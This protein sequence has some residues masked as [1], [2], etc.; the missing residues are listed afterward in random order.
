MIFFGGGGGFAMGGAITDTEVAYLVSC[1]DLI[2]V[3]W[4]IRLKSKFAVLFKYIKYSIAY[5]GPVLF[6]VWP[7]RWDR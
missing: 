2:D 4:Y 7:D 1:Y 6:P 5:L 3:L